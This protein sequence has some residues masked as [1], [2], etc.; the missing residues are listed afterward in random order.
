MRNAAVSPLLINCYH[1]LIAFPGEVCYYG[2]RKEI[3]SPL[4]ARKGARVTPH[5]LTK[6]NEREKH[7]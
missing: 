7:K 1:F 3:D 2:Q 4:G 6:L 5:K